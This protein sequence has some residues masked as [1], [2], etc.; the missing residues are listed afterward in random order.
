MGMEKYN[1]LLFWRRVMSNMTL[2]KLTQDG[3]SGARR[4]LYRLTKQARHNGIPILVVRQNIL[5]HHPSTIIKAKFI[6]ILRM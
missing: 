5:N 3:L 1:I 2:G 6:V 4:Y